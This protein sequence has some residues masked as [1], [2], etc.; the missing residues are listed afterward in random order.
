MAHRLLKALSPASA[1]SVRQTD[2]WADLMDRID[3]CIL[4]SQLDEVEAWC[5]AKEMVIPRGWDEQISEAI[6]KKREWIAS[7]DVMV[8]MRDR[9]DF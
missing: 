7:E 3:G 5:T 1:Y 8:I 2:W 6:D 4:G 9:Y